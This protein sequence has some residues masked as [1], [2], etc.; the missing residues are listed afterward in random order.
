MGG[1]SGEDPGRSEL[2]GDESRPLA[3]QRRVA[4]FLLGISCE[5]G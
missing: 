2:E 1:P 4:S 3:L 5:Q